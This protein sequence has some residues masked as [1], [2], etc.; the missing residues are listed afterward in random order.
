VNTDV[1]RV[2]QVLT[3]L[4]IRQ[5]CFMCQL[6]VASLCKRQPPIILYIY[7]YSLLQFMHK[8]NVS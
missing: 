5:P 1:G 6:S 8:E 4:L 7:I 3:I 2:R